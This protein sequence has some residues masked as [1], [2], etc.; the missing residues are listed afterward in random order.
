[1]TTPIDEYLQDLA[2]QAGVRIE[3]ARLRE[4]RDGEYSHASRVI[5]LRPGM[6]AR[7]HRSVLAHEL[8]HAAFGHRPSH[9][10]P[11]HAKQERMAEEWAALRLISPAD[12]RHVED[13]HDGHAGAMALELGVMRSIVDAYRGLL[14]RLGGTVYVRPRMG[15]GMWAHREE[16][17]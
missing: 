8:A 7:L 12:Y 3:Y 2:D 5:R 11:V 15:A 9:F 10:G 17:A 14:A 6:G 1:M 16:V 4:G 13:L